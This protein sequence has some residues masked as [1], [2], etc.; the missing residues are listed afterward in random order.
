MAGAGAAVS[1]CFCG[2]RIGLL[3]GVGPRLFV[4]LLLSADLAVCSLTNAIS[5]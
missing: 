3:G 5:R 4:G 2:G 1:G